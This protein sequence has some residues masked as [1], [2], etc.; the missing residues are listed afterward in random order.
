M[1]SENRSIAEIQD[2]F[3]SVFPDL[4]IRFF[5]HGHTEGVPSAKADAIGSTE[6]VGKVQAF[7][8]SGSLVL[9]PA[10]KVGDFESTM[11]EKFGLSVQVFRRSGEQWIQTTITDHWTLGHQEEEG[12]ESVDFN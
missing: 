3:Q 10:M 4:R 1:I 5:H 6:L 12:R 7:Q 11:Q 8:S 2:E 9:D